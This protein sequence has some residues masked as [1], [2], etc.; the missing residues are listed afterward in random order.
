MTTSL[1][2]GERIE[3]KCPQNRWFIET[4]IH[5][6]EN[7]I[8]TKDIYGNVNLIL[9][10]FEGKRDR[11][12]HLNNHT[13]HMIELKA[14][15]KST[16]KPIYYATTHSILFCMHYEGLNYAI[17]QYSIHNNEYTKLAQFPVNAHV[18]FTQSL[19]E[20][21]HILWILHYNEIIRFNLK[22]LKL[23]QLSTN[24]VF[25]SHPLQSVY[26]AS[27]IN[28]FHVMYNKKEYKRLKN[29][30]LQQIRDYYFVFKDIIDIIHVK[31]LNYVL[32]FDYDASR[33]YLPSVD[34]Y[35]AYM[36]ADN[37]NNYMYIKLHEFIV[38]DKLAF[39]Y[40]LAFEHI[41]FVF[42]GSEILVLD[43]LTKQQYAYN[44]KKTLSYLFTNS[45]YAIKTIHNDIHV[46]SR[47][48]SNYQFK[49]S[50]FD[51]IPNELKTFY[52]ER[53]KKL[54]FGYMRMYQQKQVLSHY[55]PVYLKHR[56]CSYFP[57]FL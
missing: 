9:L 3:V 53:Y 24:F 57:L 16:A 28:E 42:D 2:V 7:C 52:L 43:L 17:Y 15:P 35:Y 1:K 21:K 11:L 55:F 13:I 8:Q 20:S 4:I 30:N 6:D 26:I 25:G 44:G 56:I 18:P 36:N 29:G 41:L 45:I 50:L 37:P 49:F 40:I 46:F 23:K 32:L 5:I 10:D 48:N 22:T 34:V 12:S 54:I 19:D 14:P 51:I 27:P 47:N 31:S 38:T 39:E 33:E